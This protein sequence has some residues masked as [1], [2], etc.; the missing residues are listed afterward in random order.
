MSNI[1]GRLWSYI[2]NC[3]SCLKAEEQIHIEL[4]RPISPVELPLRIKI[5]IERVK[6]WQEDP[7]Y[8]EE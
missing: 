5:P 6:N 8:R 3:L 2:L 4:S 7:L 1:A